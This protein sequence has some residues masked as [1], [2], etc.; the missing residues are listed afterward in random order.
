[1]ERDRASQRVRRTEDERE[2]V[3]LRKRR[4][5]IGM[6][7]WRKGVLG[8]RGLGEMGRAIRGGGGAAAVAGAELCVGF[9]FG[10]WE[11]ERLGVESEKEVVCCKSWRFWLAPSAARVKE[12]E[13]ETKVI[14]AT[15]NSQ[16]SSFR[17]HFKTSEGRYSLS[18][19]K[20]HP[21]GLLH[22]NLGKVITQVPEPLAIS[23]QI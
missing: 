14:M 6:G 23:L 16:S 4:I 3:R 7:K 13:E 11:Q 2:R 5:G 22:Y 9:Y 20:T 15:S 21:T 8:E 18:H 10:V 19:E 1:M 12:E 17:S